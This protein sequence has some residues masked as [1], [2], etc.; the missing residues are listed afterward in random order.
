MG[1]APRPAKENIHE[2]RIRKTMANAGDPELQKQRGIPANFRNA[3]LQG[4]V[5]FR[6][7]MFSY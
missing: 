7:P 2:S 5:I 4:S 1:R 3:A 6:S